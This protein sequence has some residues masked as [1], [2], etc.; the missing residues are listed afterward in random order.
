MADLF[1]R[2]KKM[3]VYN[4]AGVD[5]LNRALVLYHAKNGDVTEAILSLRKASL[6]S[7]GHVSWNEED[8]K[9]LADGAAQHHNDLEEIAKL[10]PN[11]KLGD[12]VKRYYV[13]VG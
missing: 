3:A 1:E 12:V 4:T 8:R 2:V 5:A 10:L 9:K 13:Q 11:K 6:G 7:L